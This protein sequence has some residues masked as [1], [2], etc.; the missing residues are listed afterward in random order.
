MPSRQPGPLH[1]EVPLWAG[2]PVLEANPKIVALLAE[3]G[4]LLNQPAR[5]C[6]TVSPLLALQAPGAFPR[7]Q[8]VVRAPGESGDSNSLREKRWRN[9]PHPVDPTWARIASAV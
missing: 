5:R 9:R 6:A 3:T 7:H 8:P 4:F 2:Q 1:R